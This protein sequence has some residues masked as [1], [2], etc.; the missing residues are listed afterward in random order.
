MRYDTWMC[1]I[2]G[3]AVILLAVWAGACQRGDR[4][5]APDDRQAAATEPSDDSDERY[6]TGVAPGEIPAGDQRDVELTLQP[7]DGLKVNRE[8]PNWSLELQPPSGLTLGET[9]F[10]AEQFELEEQ[11]ARVA[12]Q[13][14]ADE[15]G[16]YEV[17][18]NAEFS[19][20]NDETCHI[21]RDEQ[22]MFRVRIAS[23]DGNPSER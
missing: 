13:I 19:V 15:P 6:R 11:S 22:V 5:E 20:C 18:A 23:S 9:S 4:V 7:G 21:L 3:A 17:P 2:G 14:D 8:Y 10:G 12:T 1:R 16:A